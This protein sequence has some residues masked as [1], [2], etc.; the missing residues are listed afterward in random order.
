MIIHFHPEAR[1]ELLESV[2]YYNERAT[3]L[4]KQFLE[5]VQNTLLLIENH[6]HLG[7]PLTK[8]DRRMVVQRF[9]YAIIYTVDKNQIEIHALMHLHRDPG[10]WQARK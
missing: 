1:L 3:G 10:Y 4:G 7:F 9:P 5:E 8:S 2:K 6:P